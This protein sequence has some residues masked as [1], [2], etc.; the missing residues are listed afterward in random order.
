MTKSPSL[1]VL[2][3]VILNLVISTPA[4]AFVTVSCTTGAAQ[5]GNFTI[6]SGTTVTLGSSCAGKATIPNTVTILDEGAFEDAVGLAEIEFQAGSSLLEI[7]DSAFFGSSLTAIRIPSTVTSIGGGAFLKTPKLT[8]VIFES[9]S[10]LQSIGDA[11]FSE[12]GVSG[13]VIP[14]SVTSIGIR[15]FEKT[16]NLGAVSFESGTAITSIPHRVFSQSG[17]TSIS[18]PASLTS[19]GAYCFESSTSLSSVSFAAGSSLTSIG[20]EAF[21]NT[22]LTGI[23]FPASLTTVGDY[24]F[25]GTSDLETVSFEGGST[26]AAISAGMFHYSGLQSITLPTTITSIG[27]SAFYSNLRLS[28]I[29][30]PAGVSSLGANSFGTSSVLSEVKFLGSAAPTVGA[31]AFLGVATGAKAVVSSSATGFGNRGSIWNGL[32]VDWPLE[33]PDSSSPGGAVAAPLLQAQPETGA[34]SLPAGLGRL[35]KKQKEALSSLIGSLDRRVAMSVRVAVE[36]KPGLS[37]ARQRALALKK[38][39]AI[40]G[41]LVSLGFGKK[42]ISISSK[43]LRTGKAAKTTLAWRSI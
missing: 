24:A 30:I 4:N 7:R 14:A 27:E 1:I 28:S 26:L 19:I 37:K 29:T 25:E 13:L 31:N 32:V 38:A 18:I 16:P 12:S 42:S 35:G 9:G 17:I 43:I 23:T 11:A 41:H 10:S 40:R 36:S 20:Y 5:T 39:R 3:S 6:T 21:V 2:L 22:G 34:A 33:A 8:S 15:A